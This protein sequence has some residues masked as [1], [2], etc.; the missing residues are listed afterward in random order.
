MSLKI[1]LLEGE[2]QK[3]ELPFPTFVIGAIAMGIFIALAIVTW[4]YKDVANRH[5]HKASNSSHH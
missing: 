4:S 1:H 2:L 3:I 5:D